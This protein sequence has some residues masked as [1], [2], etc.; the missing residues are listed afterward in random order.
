MQTLP[1]S[2]VNLLSASWKG[3][4]WGH[5][6]SWLPQSSK[7]S[8]RLQIARAQCHTGTLWNS[9][10]TRHCQPPC[11]VAFCGGVQRVERTA[12]LAKIACWL[13]RMVSSPSLLLWSIPC[14]GRRAALCVYM[15]CV[16][17]LHCPSE[18]WWPHHQFRLYGKW[19]T[20]LSQNSGFYIALWDKTG[21]AQDHGP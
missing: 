21:Y 1:P 2:S 13:R 14:Q 5:S 18:P 4:R 10:A 11:V 15:Q 17:A 7:L 8:Q 3:K 6:A 19:A 9:M 12:K 16:T 20:G